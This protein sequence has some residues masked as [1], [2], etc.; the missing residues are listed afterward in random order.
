MQQAALML[1]AALSFAGVAISTGWREAYPS[2][3][4]TEY[5]IRYLPQPE[6][7]PIYPA[8]RL[9]TVDAI[10]PPKAN[11]PEDVPDIVAEDDTPSRGHS[12]HRRHYRRHWRRQ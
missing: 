2:C 10:E 12:R 9:L 7:Q 3:P 11:Q 4:A 6:P 1:I 5:V 8:P